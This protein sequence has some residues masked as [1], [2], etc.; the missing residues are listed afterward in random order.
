MLGEFFPSLAQT[1]SVLRRMTSVSSDSGDSGVDPVSSL[2]FFSFTCNIFD[3]I[4][5][6]PIVK[7]GRFL[8]VAFRQRLDPKNWRI[9]S[10]HMDK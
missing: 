6:S 3:R 2:V 4:L 9:F 1:P 5:V 8:S 10:V 7:S